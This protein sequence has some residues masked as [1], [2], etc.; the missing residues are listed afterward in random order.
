[1][2]INYFVSWETVF[3]V[4]LFTNWQLQFLHWYLLL[5]LWIKLFLTRYS[6]LQEGQVGFEDPSHLSQDKCEGSSNTLESKKI[7]EE[8]KNAKIFA[9]KKLNL[10]IIIKIWL[11]QQI[12]SQGYT[13][14]KFHLITKTVLPLTAV[15][16]FLLLLL[17]NFASL[18]LSSDN[19]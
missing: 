18:R 14:Y 15:V 19:F 13:R 4:E 11:Y 9:I 6:E 1:M 17:L 8:R 16:F 3:L 7:N 12:L 2:S 10:W 5:L